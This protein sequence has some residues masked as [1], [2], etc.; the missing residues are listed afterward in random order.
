MFQDI[1]DFIYE[2]FYSARILIG[3]YIVA[4]FLL[5][6]R[7]K[8]L[9]PA[10]ISSVVVVLGAAS[11]SIIL[12]V[13]KSSGYSRS[14][15]T[16]IN[17]FWYCGLLLL[18]YGVFVLNMKGSLSETLFVFACGVLMESMAFGLFRIT[19]DLNIFT[20]RVNTIASEICDIT[21]TAVLY[22]IFF[23]IFK[24]I[25]KNN[26]KLNAGNSL[27]LVYLLVIAVGMF[28]RLG[29]QDIYEYINDTS[30]GWIGSV[31]LVIVPLVFMALIL[32][33]AHISHLNYEK[34]TLEGMLD[35]KERQYKLSSENVEIIN[36]KCH[37]IK[38][39]LR[40]FEFVDSGDR[41]QAIAEMEKSISIYDSFIQTSCPAL[42]TILSEKT[43]FCNENGI[44]LSCNVNGG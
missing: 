27:S 11:F 41:S 23:L 14:F 18:L 29:M 9:L 36:R 44:T 26:D 5:K 34:H 6:R 39:Q 30:H 13:L 32:L 40:A 8:S 35:E 17:G 10:I 22:T 12:S 38:R 20:L 24:K 42:N 7:Y 1:L 31:T 37:D 33:V 43:L 25:F 3:A 4:A 2:S 19:Y 21:I 15:I 16:I 28:L